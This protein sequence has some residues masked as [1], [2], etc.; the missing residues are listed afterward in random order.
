[1]H[2]NR[3]GEARGNTWFHMR[4]TEQEAPW[5][6]VGGRPASAIS[7]LELLATTL[8]LVLLAPPELDSPGAAGTVAVTG[9]TDSQVSA[10][11]VTRGLTTSFPLCAVA[12]ELAAQLEERRAELFLGWIPR[13]VNREA[14]RL[15]DGVWEGFDTKLRVHC[16][17]G[18]VR[19]LVLPKLLAAGRDFYA[20]RQKVARAKEK[21]RGAGMPGAAKR[22]KLRE[23]EPW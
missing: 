3:G 4:L 7:T 21:P 5:A 10:A 18:E 14:D 2:G 19:W 12:M 11:V 23:R 9:L 20:Q 15:A 8:G 17:L 22:Q 16:S 6:F 13:D 1:M